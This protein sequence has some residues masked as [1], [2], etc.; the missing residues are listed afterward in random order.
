MNKKLI[1]SVLL[2]FIMVMPLLAGLANAGEGNVI[3]GLCSSGDDASITA[4]IPARPNEI[5]TDRIGLS[6]LSS[7][8]E[9]YMYDAGNLM[10]HWANG[11]EAITM[12][13]RNIAGEGWA[14]SCSISL[15]TGV[16]MQQN[17]DMT[18]TKMVTP[19][20]EWDGFGGIDVTWSDP[21]DPN[22]IGYLVYWSNDGS[23]WVL[24]G[25]S[26]AVI[27]GQWWSQP[28]DIELADSW[29]VGNTWN[30]VSPGF[31]GDYYC[32]RYV[33]QGDGIYG[34]PT[35]EHDS[36]GL[37]N[38]DGTF[39]PVYGP[40]SLVGPQHYDSYATGPEGSSTSLGPF[41]MM[42]QANCGC[43]GDYDDIY[44]SNDNN[45]TWHY[46]GSVPVWG[47]SVSWV[48]PSFGT[49]WWYVIANDFSGVPGP[50]APT[51]G[52]SAEAGPY[53]ITPAPGP[54]TDIACHKSGNDIYINWATGTGPF[55]IWRSNYFD[56]TGFALHDTTTNYFYTDLGA[57]A[58][59]NN[60]SYVVRSQGET[61]NSNMGFKLL[62]PLVDNGLAKNWISL[63]YKCDI[64]TA[65]ELM[66]DIN[67]DGPGG[68]VVSITTR[69]DTANQIFQS[70]TDIGASRI[71]VNFAIVPGIGYQVKIKSGMSMD[72]KI[73]GAA[74]DIGSD[75]TLSL[76][77][78]SLAY[79]WVA[80]PY[81]SAYA[82]ADELMDAINADGPGGDSI[83]ILTQWDD[84]S[85]IFQS[86]TDIGA[87]RI[88]VNFNIL[89]GHCYQARMVQGITDWVISQ[90][91]LGP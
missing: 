54:P 88:G 78:N 25:G 64:T 89:P 36:W 73:V 38:P 69:W 79:N 46:I 80:L 17:P 39:V 12:A 71:G 51:P 59:L 75:V 13:A 41:D 5:V 34:F 1:F 58:D 8:S 16:G 33:Y 86:R 60:Y 47:T 87:S 29:I 35:Q 90:N 4:W 21:G 49:Y 22:I 57:L 68:D 70:R 45:A 66:D 72:W 83:N 42:F 15:I 26:T 31:V 53:V 7:T 11:D 52:T 48:A 37:N 62:R 76:V 9:M 20:A 24:K 6:G 10:T 65:D 2:S 63:P 30:D 81:N 74:Q 18:L 43:F 55:E 32:L 23:S 50:F 14:S 82:N 28:C 19:T 56:G 77:N 91:V 3:Y 67:A 44:Y 61:T 84:S 27:A 40:I 85:Q